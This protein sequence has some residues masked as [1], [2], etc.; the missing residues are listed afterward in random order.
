MNW[1]EELETLERRLRLMLLE[2]LRLRQENQ[3]LKARM[4]EMANE[5]ALLLHHR[6]EVRTRV[7]SMIHRLKSLEIER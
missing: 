6:D 7:E 5:R 3:S 2:T 1:Q 4:G